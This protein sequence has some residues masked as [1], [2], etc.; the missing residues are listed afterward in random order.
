ME[1]N[2]IGFSNIRLPDNQNSFIYTYTQSNTFPEEVFVHEFLHT[3]E[4]NE[5]ENGNDIIKL[6]DYNKYGYEESDTEGLKQWYT[7]YMQNKIKGEKNKGLTDFA[8][9][10]MPIHESNFKNPI[11]LDYLD[12]PDNFIEEIRS[13]IK[14]VTQ[15]FVKEETV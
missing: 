1:Y 12:E 9:R 7:D 15:L 2:Q 3:L 14:R 4:R 5:I 8:Y 11:A 13:I 6:H 10:S